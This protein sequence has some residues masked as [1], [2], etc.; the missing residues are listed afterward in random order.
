MSGRVLG[1]LACV[2]RWPGP[3]GATRIRNQINHDPFRVALGMRV[4]R[5]SGDRD[6]SL[7]YILE[8]VT[9]NAFRNL[10]SEK[11]LS[12]GANSDPP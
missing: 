2:V 7:P 5:G 4:Y 10:T 1:T 6:D 12:Y 3:A 8:E 11:Q 9:A